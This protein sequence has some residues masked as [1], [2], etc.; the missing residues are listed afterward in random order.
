MAV[1]ENGGPCQVPTGGTVESHIN[2]LC[3]AGRMD[4][5]GNRQL[6]VRCTS[7]GYWHSRSPQI[8]FGLCGDKQQFHRAGV[9]LRDGGGGA[10]QTRGASSQ[11][12]TYGLA[13]R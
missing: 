13:R 6:S 9:Q 4:T 10:A 3:S 2:A 12:P 5:D 8:P 11:S 1:P 7:G